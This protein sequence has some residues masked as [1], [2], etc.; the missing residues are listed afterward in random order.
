MERA[1]NKASRLLQIEALLVGLPERLTPA[2]IVFPTRVGC[3][4]SGDLAE[5]RKRSLLRLE[6]KE[7]IVGDGII[8]SIRFNVS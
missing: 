5:A 1:G 7:Y 2:E 8:L 6:G 3:T 4:A